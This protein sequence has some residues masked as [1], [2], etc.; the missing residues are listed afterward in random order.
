MNQKA[1]TKREFPYVTLI[2][3]VTL[4]LVVAILGYTVVD[5]LGIIGHFDNAAKSNHYKLNENQVSVYRFHVAQS[6]LMTEFMYYQY[7]LMQDIYGYTQVFASAAEY[8]N[9][10][11]PSSIKTNVYDSSAY[12]YAEQYLTYCEGAEDE[13]VYA[14]IKADIEA[15]IDEYIDGLKETAKINGVSFSQ[16]LKKWMGNG[17]SE[18]DVR[19]AM[20]YYYIGIEYAERLHDR[21]GDA[22]T[23]E[24]IEKYRDDNKASFYTSK[25][26]SYALL[27]N[28]MKD[29]IE[30]CKTVD[31]VKTVIVDYFMTNN[32][33]ALYKTKILDAEIEDAAGKDQT[34]ADVR[35]TILA[36]QKIGDAKEIFKSDDKDDYKKAA[37]TIVTELNTK[38]NSEINKIKE[39]GSSAY[40]DP[41]DEK[42]TDLAKW[43]FATGRKAEDYTLIKSET[44]STD[45]T[46]G[47]EEVKTTYTWYIVEEAMV[48]DTE[49]TKNAYYIL[50]SDDEE[51]T[52]GALTATQKA[53]AMMK[54]LTATKTPEKFAELVEKYAPGYSSEIREKLSYETVKGT[55]EKLADWLYDKDRKEGDIEKFEVT[56]TKDTKKVTGYYV[57]YFV[58]ANEETWKMNGR[59]NVASEKLGDWYEEAVE[60]YGVKVDYTFETE[61]ETTTSA[62]TSADTKPAETT[63]T[64][65]AGT[66][67]A[68]E[69]GTTEPAESDTA[70]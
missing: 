45:N 70:A 40:S 38:A 19:I 9:Y 57:A 4:V 33:E 8:A 17:V 48:L 46:T 61:A 37:Y 67:A 54:D 55:N 25:Y 13:G 30:K 3:I 6:Q 68:T 44:K 47:K 64:T 23:I 12:S 62:T 1:K 35:T 39:D 52:E 49:L 59:E 63:A 14:E 15:D 29:A 24:E 43:L 65:E 16:Y 10:M 51:G 31:D 36:L 22:T 53:E 60:K 28:D 56:D 5:S 7:G 18:K 11:I 69:A 21:F 26:T 20:E 34:K 50:L 58:D 32:F 2:L 42:A 41:T 66:T 27:N